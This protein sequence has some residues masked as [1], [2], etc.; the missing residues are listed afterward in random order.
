[1]QDAGY[2][3]GDYFGIMGKA[4][5]QDAGQEE[6]QAADV[7]ASPVLEPLPLDMKVVCRC[8][9]CLLNDGY[10]ACRLRQITIDKGWCN[11]YRHP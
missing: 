5:P 2:K 8:D 11:D 9:D 4:A 6:A 3:M 1:M 7:Q 10:G